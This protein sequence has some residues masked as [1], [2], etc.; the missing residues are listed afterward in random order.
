[1]NKEESNPLDVLTNPDREAE[2][3]E[4]YERALEKTQ[5]EQE[6]MNDRENC[7]CD[8]H[9]CCSVH[10][11]EID[12]RNNT[13][14]TDPSYESTMKH[15]SKPLVATTLVNTPDTEKKHQKHCRASLG[16]V[17]SCL[18]DVIDFTVKTE[19]FTPTTPDTEGEAYGRGYK[20]GRFDSEMDRL[21]EGPATPETN[22]CDSMTPEERE[23]QSKIKVTYTTSNTPDT[24]WRTHAQRADYFEPN[25]LVMTLD[26]IDLLLTYRDTYWKERV[27]KE[28]EAIRK[29]ERE[30]P[31]EMADMKKWEVW[32]R[33]TDEDEIYNQALDTLLDNLK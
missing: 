11:A 15:L 7:G 17:C 4:L 32:D 16:F 21:N 29:P 28:V 18:P 19:E 3:R 25:T 23:A 31:N 24:E 14:D 33:L 9:D 5:A 1:M 13:P 30:E 10:Q 8:V 12:A 26:N 2:K 22:Y 27:R 20:Q 6:S